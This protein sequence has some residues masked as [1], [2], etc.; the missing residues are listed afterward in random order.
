MYFFLNWRAISNPKLVKPIMSATTATQHV[1]VSVEQMIPFLKDLCTL[2]NGENNNNEEE[3]EEEMID[4]SNCDTV[5]SDRES[6]EELPKQQ[7]N[8]IEM[9]DMNAVYEA[10][11]TL[12]VDELLEGTII[13]M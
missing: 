5:K 9:P 11:G 6:V 1:V 2:N 13:S 8:L 4:P 12:Q 7:V 3:E 10:Y